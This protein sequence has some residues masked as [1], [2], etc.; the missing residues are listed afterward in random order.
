MMTWFYKFN[1]SQ[2]IGDLALVSNKLDKAL[3]EWFWNGRF[4]RPRLHPVNCEYTILRS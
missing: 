4:Y 3:L 1:G 2:Y